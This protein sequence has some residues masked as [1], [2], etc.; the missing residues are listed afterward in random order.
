[1]RRALE[2]GALLLFVVLVVGVAFMAA[3]Y[4]QPRRIRGTPDDLGQQ[5]AIAAEHKDW[6]WARILLDSG[7]DPTVTE[8]DG[9]HE[10]MLQP[11][12][13][14][15]WLGLRVR[16]TSGHPTILGTALEQAIEQGNADAVQMLLDHHVPVTGENVY[17][18]KYSGSRGVIQ[19]MEDYGHVPLGRRSIAEAPF[20]TGGEDARPAVVP[21]TIGA[22]PM[23]HLLW[24]S[25]NE[26]VLVH[27]HPLRFSA[28]ELPSG[29]ES[30]LPELTQNWAGQD[31]FDPD[32]LAL[33][34]DAKWLVGFG[35]TEDH[36]TWRATQVRGAAIQEWDRVTNPKASFVIERGPLIAW[37]DG[38]RW[39]EINHVPGGVTGDYVVRTR[40]L[41]SPGAQ[42]LPLDRSGCEYLTDYPSTLFTFITPDRGFLRGQVSRGGPPGSEVSDSFMAD[43]AAGPDAWHMVSRE[44]RADATSLSGWFNRCVPSPDGRR[45]AWLDYF[46]ESEA[47]DVLISDADGTHFRIAYEQLCPVQ[48]W[49]EG[50][51]EAPWMHALEWTPSGDALLFWR[52]EYGFGGLAYLP[53][54]ADE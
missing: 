12:D 47:N 38:V 27:T 16:W 5:L 18:A 28:L 29:E 2:I 51:A 19:L 3:R 9:A 49:K 7:A 31:A 17:H 45:L 25:P 6:R 48:H 37:R 30:D 43:V 24:L 32:M 10:A 15:N 40:I 50:R 22:V 42:E 1:M 20:A 11:P 39:V 35:G 21:N 26:I 4:I 34:P 23:R 44:L 52:G 53:I 54:S 14:R 8:L 46:T 33:S 13:W 36:P 41:G